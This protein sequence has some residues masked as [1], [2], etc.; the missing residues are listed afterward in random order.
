LGPPA[1]T[2]EYEESAG[3]KSDILP[4]FRGLV[5][6]ALASY[7][8][9]LLR[10]KT[11]RPATIAGSLENFPGA[12]RRLRSGKC[13][14]FLGHGVFG[15][16]GPLSIC[17][18]RDKL[19]DES[20]KSCKESFESCPRSCLATAAEYQELLLGRDQFL[21][22]LQEIIEDQAKKIV[23]AK[24]RNPATLALY[25]LI[26]KLKPPLI[27][28]ATEDL[29]LEEQL[30]KAGKRCLILSHVIRLKKDPLRDPQIDQ[31][32]LE[33][34]LVFKGFDDAK[35]EPRPADAIDELI[36]E[37]SLKDEDKA[38]IIYKPLGSPLLHRY[39]DPKLGIDT[40]VMTEAD[41][42]ILLK[43]L[44]NQESGVPKAFFTFFQEYPPIFL[45]YPM[46]VWH[47][48]LVGQV[49]QSIGLTRSSLKPF[50]AVRKTD[51][52][53]E[54]K[55]WEKLEIKLVPMDPNEFSQKVA[56]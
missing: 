20:C 16:K 50:F 13:I 18:L 28:S 22:V 29:L 15:K 25:D 2:F 42:L 38:F 19:G 43:R 26:Q 14:P 17:E 56:P 35:P 48:R 41:Y 37:E 31:K 9:K 24:A 4:N 6:T 40:V 44:E 30:S 49:F 27:V 8:E 51:S 54:E 3:K 10:E 32:Y 33:K 52:P 12:S 21:E 36:A 1:G 23:E 47:F 46:D 7:K 34:V 55:A 5:R 45:G 39:L 53:M 11:P